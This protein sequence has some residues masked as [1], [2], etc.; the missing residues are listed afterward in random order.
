MRAELVAIHTALTTFAEHDW[1]GIF[2]NSLSNLQ[3]IRRHNTNPGIRTN[4]HYHNHILLLEII[5]NL[6]DTRRLAGFHMT[7]HKLRAHMNI[8][9]NELADAAATLAVCNFNSLP[10]AQITRVDT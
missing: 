8:R 3:A 5:T 1:L 2:T 7:L 9:G 10:P 6:L 4:L